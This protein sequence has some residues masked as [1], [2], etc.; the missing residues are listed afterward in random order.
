MSKYNL[1]CDTCI[2]CQKEQLRFDY[3]WYW[4]ASIHKGTKLLY[5][6]KKT[7]KYIRKFRTKC[8][9]YQNT[10]L[11]P[12]LPEPKEPLYATQKNPEHTPSH[13]PTTKKKVGRY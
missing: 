13:K 11:L 2:Y 3:P 12:Y 10:V 1:L 4:K 6:C 9:H 5:F 8:K 7:Q